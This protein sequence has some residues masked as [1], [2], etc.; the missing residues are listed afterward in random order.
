MSVAKAIGMAIA[1]MVVAMVAANYLFA[2]PVSWSVALALPVGGVVLLATLLSGVADAN[3]EAVPGDAATTTELHASMLAAR[4]AEAARDQQRF[5]TRIRPR[6]AKIALARVR[7]RV[8]DV[9]RVDDPRAREVLGDDLY[10]LLTDPSAELPAPNQL[11]AM[12]AR[13]EEV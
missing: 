10:R 1:A 9:S 11:A 12:L 13:L 8:A 6:L 4:L 7:A 3:W 5:S 2:T